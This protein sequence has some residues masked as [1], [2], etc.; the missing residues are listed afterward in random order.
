VTYIQ[1]KECQVSLRQPGNL[2]RGSSDRCAACA[3]KL[4]L[5]IP[6]Q[7]RPDTRRKLS[8]DMEQI[9]DLLINSCIKE[10]ENFGNGKK[11]CNLEW[12]DSKLASG[13]LGKW[14][15]GAG[16]HWRHLKALC[17]EF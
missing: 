11:G 14:V 16:P 4:S 10:Q 13:N 2:W 15:A 1:I 12:L 7:P 8:L 9:S 17:R 6:A 3:G 5:S